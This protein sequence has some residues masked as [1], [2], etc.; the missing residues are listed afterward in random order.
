[1]KVVILC[2]GKGT[3]LSE[4]T[5]VRPKP[6]VEIGEMPIVWHIMNSYAKHSFKDFYLALGYKGDF[7]KRYF[8]DFNKSVNDVKI[9]LGD[10]SVKNL[11]NK[12]VDWE[13]NLVDTGD[14]SMTGGRLRRLRDELKGETF[15]LTYG[16]GVCDV[17]LT[18]LYDFHKA[19]GKAATVTAVRPPARFGE[20]LMDGDQV[21]E[22][23]EKPRASVGWING[24][25][26]I[27]E[28]KVF[29]YLE[30][31]STILEKAPLENLA[32]S[33]ELMAYK[34]D[35]FWQCMDTMRDK[36]LLCELWDSG[37]APW[38]V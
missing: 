38:K 36:N 4:E 27:F 16:D 14:E 12:T 23:K 17:D 34:H 28:S 33:G 25:Y 35:G 3:R 5:V 19:H 13:V 37:K 29:D 6:M 26:F 20:M 24:G 2:G 30:D 31:D 7:I 9:N 32:N 21:S 8:H 18:K 1:M 22:F 10:G 15:M 11:N